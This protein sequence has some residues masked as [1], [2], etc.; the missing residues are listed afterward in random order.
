M[1]S[2]LSTNTF[3]SA[4]LVY[5]ALLF[6]ILMAYLGIRHLKHRG[7]SA[8]KQE[9]LEA[10]LTEPPS[11]HPKIDHAL[12]QGCGSCIAACPEQPTHKVLGVL[13]NK[14]ELIDPSSCIGH[15]ACATACP[16]DAISL[17]FGTEKEVSISPWFRSILKP[18]CPACL[19]QAN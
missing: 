1:D 12:C 14:A 11:L 19:S 9:T 3:N 5:G 10:G 16:Y 6:L 7:Y 15:G 13:H 17:V 4:F 8:I 2:I 18:I